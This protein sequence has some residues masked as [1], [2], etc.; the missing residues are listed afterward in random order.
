[1]RRILKVR[2][3]KASAVSGTLDTAYHE[4]NVHVQMQTQQYLLEGMKHSREALQTSF[5]LSSEWFSQ[6]TKATNAQQLQHVNQQYGTK[7]K[8]M[9]D[10][11]VTTLHDFKTI[12]PP[13]AHAQCGLV[14]GG[15]QQRQ[16]FFSARTFSSLFVLHPK[17][18]KKQ[19]KKVGKK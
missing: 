1:M 17:T 15:D 2:E 5:D 10:S 12:L 13:T 9:T 4:E 14:Y 8:D 16:K 19:G 6:V 3:K 11:L 18:Q 7:M